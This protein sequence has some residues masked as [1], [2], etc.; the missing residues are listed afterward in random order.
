[1]RMMSAGARG[2]SGEEGLEHGNREALGHSRPSAHGILSNVKYYDTTNNGITQANFE[3]FP[4]SNSSALA[5]ECQQG[6]ACHQQEGRNY[7]QRQDERKPRE[8]EEAYREREGGHYA[9]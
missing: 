8:D 3:A 7:H 2:R 4:F 6:D 1:M 9:S 5:P